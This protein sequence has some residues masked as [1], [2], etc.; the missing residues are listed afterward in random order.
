[1]ATRRGPRRASEKGASLPPGFRGQSQLAFSP[2]GLNIMSYPGQAIV[3]PQQMMA[4]QQA[5]QMQMQ[6][7][8]H[9]QQQQQLTVGMGGAAPS[10]TL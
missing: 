6:Q 1:M 7:V 5:A 9:Q 8:Y 10:R 4:M 3:T 2:A